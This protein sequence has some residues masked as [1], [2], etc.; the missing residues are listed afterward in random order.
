MTITVPSNLLLRTTS[1]TPKVSAHLVYQVCPAYLYRTIPTTLRTLR[2][3][4]NRLYP[5]PAFPPRWPGLPIRPLNLTNITRSIPRSIRRSTRL[6]IIL[7]TSLCM[8]FLPNTL[9]PQPV[10][11]LIHRRILSTCLRQRLTRVLLIPPMPR[12]LPRLRLKFSQCLIQLSLR[13]SITFGPHAVPHLFRNS[14]PS[15]T[16]ESPCVPSSPSKLH[17][18]STY[19]N[20]P[21]PGTR[22][23]Y[24]R[25]SIPTTGAQPTR[26]RQRCHHR[27]DFLL[28]QHP[29]E[30]R[31]AMLRADF[32]LCIR[33]TARP[34][35]RPHA[36][37]SR[38]PLRPRRP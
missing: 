31:I 3:R 8:G 1:S 7:R 9:L 38:A 11:L 21:A 22:T 33:C 29:Y 18:V 13:I 4:P 17:R 19:L 20:L 28:W 24:L 16:S 35:L 5:T 26:S 15:I 32:R 36:N 25:F 6:S 27:L 23:N 37:S 30:E 14:R 2:R 34:H 10:S 12:L